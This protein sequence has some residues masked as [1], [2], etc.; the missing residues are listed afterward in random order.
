MSVR[1]AASG[2]IDR[3]YCMMIGGPA[4]TVD[5]LD[6]ILNTL[7]PGKG[8]IDVT[9]HREKADPRPEQGYMYCGP[10]G[11]GPLRQNGP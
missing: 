9:K 4:G 6:P 3:G 11:A 7:A 10:A 8:T 1:P 2:A 5:R